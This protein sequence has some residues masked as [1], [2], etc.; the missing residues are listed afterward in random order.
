M[1][2]I[3]P[4]L[5]RLY[6]L[7]GQARRKYLKTCSGPVIDCLCEC[8]KNLLKGRVSVKAKQLKALRRYRRFLRK[9]ALKKTSQ[10]ERRRIIQK[11]G[12][13]GALLPALISGISG[14][15]ARNG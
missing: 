13:L 6:R 8:I 2:E 15:L 12:F 10:H 4:E 11:G 7:K 3:L 9:V 14:L 1:R 5:K